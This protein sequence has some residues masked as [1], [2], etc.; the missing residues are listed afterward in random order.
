M[1]HHFWCFVAIFYIVEQISFVYL[2]IW[3]NERS[4]TFWKKKKTIWLSIVCLFGQSVRCFSPC[5]FYFGVIFLLYINQISFDFEY[6]LFCCFCFSF[7]NRFTKN[8]TMFFS[9]CVEKRQLQ[10]HNSCERNAWI[11]QKSAFI[12]SYYEILSKFE[13]VQ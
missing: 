6:F 7:F 5:F 13:F 8:L 9:L 2:R 10:M 12:I 11:F 4:A 1:I 3:V